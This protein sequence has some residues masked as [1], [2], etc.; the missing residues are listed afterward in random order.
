MHNTVVSCWNAALQV[1][2]LVQITLSFT[3]TINAVEFKVCISPDPCPL[4]DKNYY[5]KNKN[6]RKNSYY[7]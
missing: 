6:H 3:R 2:L 5:K 1:I 4:Y 7:T